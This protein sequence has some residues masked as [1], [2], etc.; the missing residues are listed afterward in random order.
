MEATAW[1]DV[2]GAADLPPDRLERVVHLGQVTTDEVGE[3][4][5]EGPQAYLVAQGSAT[6]ELPVHFHTVEQFQYFAHGRGVVGTH[7]VAHGT[8][9]YS[10][11]LTPYG[12]LRPGREGMSY[13][14]LRGVHDGGVRYM[15]AARDELRDLLGRSVRPPAERR[16][17]SIDLTGPVVGGGW[18]HLADEPD[19]LRVSVAELPSGERADP[20][21]VEAGGAYVVVVAGSTSDDDGALGPPAMR[22]LPPGEVLEVRA[23]TLGARVAALQFPGAPRAAG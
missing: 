22:W 13:L 5:R 15:P 21:R 19:G 3:A 18:H 9:H 6:D 20:L 1:I 14:T 23:G 16:N 17:V 11:P 10:D 7:E 4:E 8:V 12:P 2:V